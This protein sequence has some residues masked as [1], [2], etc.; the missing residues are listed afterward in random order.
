MSG[1]SERANGRASGPVLQYSWRFWTIV[2]RNDDKYVCHSVA[3]LRIASKE[4]LDIYAEN[5]HEQ[6]SFAQLLGALSFTE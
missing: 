1:A 2:Q 4:S 6:H 3:E 5:E